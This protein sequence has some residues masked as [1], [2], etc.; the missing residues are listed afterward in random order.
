[1]NPLGYWIIIPIIL[2]ILCLFGL[3]KRNK[4]HEG[5]YGYIA[6]M[7]EGLFQLFWII[8]ILFIWMIYFAVSLLLK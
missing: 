7:A 8:P 2:T 1:M 5:N 6:D 3:F 4:P